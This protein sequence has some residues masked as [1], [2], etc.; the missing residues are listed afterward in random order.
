MNSLFIGLGGAGTYAVAELQKK[1]KEY[2]RTVEDPSKNNYLYIDTDLAVKTVYPFI[3][4]QGDF[5]PFSDNDTPSS[6]ISINFNPTN[7][8]NPNSKRF[9]EWADRYNAEVNSTASLVKGAEGV[10]M[11]SRIALFDRHSS[12]KRTLIGKM[13]I[14]GQPVSRIYVISGTCGGTGCGSVLDILFMIQEIR[15]ENKNTR[16]PEVQLMMVMPQGYIS[17]LDTKDLRY[18]NYKLNAYGLF[19]EMNAV[20]KDLWQNSTPLKD[21]QGHYIGPDGNRVDTRDQ[22]QQVPAADSGLQFTKFSAMPV[23]SAYQNTMKFDPFSIAY[24]F[25]SYNSDTMTAYDYKQVSDFVSNFIFNLEVGQSIQGNFDSTYSNVIRLAKVHS[26]SSDY[27][28]AFSAT[29]SFMV[30]THEE[31]L[32]NYVQDKFIY[33]MMT[34][35]L[36]G[37]DDGSEV[38]VSPIT[39][40]NGIASIIDTKITAFVN[41]LWDTLQ[42]LSN[43]P[44]KEDLKSALKHYQDH[45]GTRQPQYD[46]IFGNWNVGQ[47]PNKKFNEMCEELAD[48]VNDA[49]KDWIVEFNLR[50]AQKLITKLDLMLT[51]KHNKLAKLI[52]D[53]SKEMFIRSESLKKA[54]KDTLKAYTELLVC[55]YLAINGILDQYGDEIGKFIDNLKFDTYK[56]RDGVNLNGWYAAY[57]KRLMELDADSSRMFIPAIS[58]ILNGTRL[59]DDSGFDA[60]YARLVRQDGSKP[61]MTPFV[62]TVNPDSIS[63]L[64]YMRKRSIMQSI[65][66]RD[67]NFTSKFS[68]KNLNS[69]DNVRVI[70]ETFRKETD[71]YAYEMVSSS[72]DLTITI[73]DQLG[74]DTTQQEVAQALCQYEKLIFSSSVV[75][76]TA[77]K[78]LRI[79]YVGDF[80][81]NGAIQTK[82]SSLSQGTTTMEYQFADDQNLYWH[83]RFVKIIVRMNYSIDEYANFNDYKE[84]FE[85][86]YC[87]KRAEVTFHQPFLDK[88]FWECKD[89]DVVQL[90]KDEA[91]KTSQARAAAANEQRIREEQEDRS[92]RRNA[93]GWDDPKQQI[94]AFQF[95]SLLLCE[96]FKKLKSLSSTKSFFAKF[97]VKKTSK[98]TTAPVGYDEDTK[99]LTLTMSDNYKM[100]PNASKFDITS[101]WSSK[102]TAIDSVKIQETGKEYVAYWIRIIQSKLTEA[103]LRT[104]AVNEICKKSYGYLTE[105]R[106]REIS[107]DDIRKF[108]T[109]YYDVTSQE[110]TGRD[111]FEDFLLWFN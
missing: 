85:R 33:Q 105:L 18:E 28:D 90:L 27:I 82:I 16:Y 8:N 80:T 59:S 26:A 21:A 60:K 54:V 67:Q 50:H 102:L 95:T 10:R 86:Y 53:K 20:L 17:G 35:G 25:D 111:I 74:A 91:I 98:T 1:F 93:L 96:Y 40:Q 11:L 94:L 43:N 32:K 36:V 87:Q 72:T 110:R 45:A 23:G 47:S 9:R 108:A 101:V 109:T 75:D 88:R 46:A 39:R 61:D 51:L 84:F 104:D 4:E 6:I 97:R 7:D 55:K 14:N 24:L 57:I 83:D 49:C 12:L 76:Q 65:V 38:D 5:F 37:R 58:T 106:S 73:A 77:N 31:L 41:G 62:S 63:D 100:D 3:D 92:G 13:S 29:G 30:Q 44:S 78:P 19:T 70:L 2:D 66:S 48:A 34:Y 52:D 22:A 103:D 99:K 71:R 89:A 15:T 64:L 68:P 107:A 56:L 81:T 79:L 42:Q 69:N